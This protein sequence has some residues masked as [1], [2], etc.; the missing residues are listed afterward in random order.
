[1][2]VKAERPIAGGF[3]FESQ[4]HGHAIRDHKS[5]PSP[6]QT[7]NIPV[8]I[9]GGGMAGLSAAWWMDKKGFKD[10]VLLEMEKEAG[11]NSRYGQNEI[12]A[13]PWGAHYVPVPNTDAVLV[14]E[15]FTEL[16]LLAGGKWDERW[17]CHS[18]QER[19][20]LHGRWQEGIEPD[21]G[22]TAEDR[23]QFKA[24][25]ERIREFRATR[26]FRIPMAL[27]APADSPL[28]KLS[29]RQWLE[30][31]AFK[32]EY[33]HWLADYST[34]DDYGASSADTSAWAGIH[35]FAARDHE[36]KGPLT[37]PE[38]NGW[39]LR[40]LLAKLDKYVRTNQPAIQI[41]KAGTK[42][43]IRTPDTLYKC[44][45]VIYAAPAFLLPYLDPT[46]PPVKSMVWSPWIVS[47]LTLD[48]MPEE[49]GSEPAWDNVIYRSPTL[50]YVVSTHQNIQMQTKRTVLTHYWALSHT[51]PAQ[52]RREL[53]STGWQTW[54]ERILADLER[55]HRDIRQCV[56]RVDIFRNGHAMIRPTPGFLSNPERK[57]WQT[58]RDRFY[59]ASADVSGF[60][61]FEEAQ[62]RGIEAA[63]RSIRGV[64]A[65]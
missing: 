63:R 49:K 51:T 40:K 41:T 12:S 10:F 43:E 7:V 47:N 25:D 50:G 24:F 20:F 44:G 28:D 6:K 52:A 22:L 57:S 46:V 42:W 26:Q 61:I 38:G 13:Y 5:F 23:R 60:S 19:L 30:N 36:E 9:V 35:Y 2:T 65:V 62:Y 29:F 16:G 48:R 11:G 37:W 21:I 33:L 59:Y 15:L 45:A 32:S 64:Q 53:L 18:P 31:N 39:I 17:L 14:R 4:D 55:A 27:G 1:M 56:S 54:K 8:V 34:R 3:V 58:G